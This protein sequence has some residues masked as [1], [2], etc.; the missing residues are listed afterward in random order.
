MSFRASGTTVE[1]LIYGHRVTYTQDDRQRR[2][3]H[4]DCPKYER[5]LKTYREGFCPHIVI[6]IQRARRSARPKTDC[7]CTYQERVTS[8]RCHVSVNR[9]QID[10]VPFTASIG[11]S[12]N[13]DLGINKDRVKY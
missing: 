5:I 10:Q 7:P 6:A 12:T 9:G 11:L 3:W 1:H 2:I 13:W 8:T 4:C